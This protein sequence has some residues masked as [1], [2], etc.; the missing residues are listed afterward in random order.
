MIVV[1]VTSLARG[2]IVVVGFDARPAS[3]NPNYFSAPADME[4]AVQ[5]VK[6]AREIM[7]SGAPARIW[8]GEKYAAGVTIQSDKDIEEYIKNTFF[9]N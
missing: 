1:P 2:G 5:A 4:L 9:M 7:R 3:D 8:I 6:R